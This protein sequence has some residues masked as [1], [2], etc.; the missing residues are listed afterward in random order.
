VVAGV[1][2]LLLIWLGIWVVIRDERG[3]EVGRVRLPSGGSVTQELETSS[4]RPGTPGRGVGGEGGWD[5][6]P[7][8]PSPAIAPFDA[9]GAKSHQQAWAPYLGVPVEIENSLG[10]KFMLIPPGEFD[11]GS[12]EA[13]VAELRSEGTAVKQKA[14]YILRVAAQAPRHRVR[15]TRPFWL[16]RHE[17]T[18][19]QFRR[20]V[21]DSGYQTEGE[22]DGKGGYG[23]VDGQQTQDPRFSWDAD[24]GFDQTDDH[25]LVNV[26]WS[27]AAA[28]CAW[29]SKKEGAESYLPSEA[30]WEYA[31]R[32]G[33]ATLWYSGDEANVA[34]DGHAWFDV[35]AGQKT[36][37]VGQK[38]PNAWGLFDMHGNVWEWCRDWFDPGY[39]SKS[40][41]NDP[42]GPSE[43]SG[44]VYRGGGWAS[45][46]C[47][48][49]TSYRF[50][51][52][53]FARNCTRGFRLARQVAWPEAGQT[54]TDPGQP[55]ATPAQTPP[56]P[57]ASSADPGTPGSGAGGEGETSPLPGTP[58][59]GVGGEGGWNLPPNAPPPAIAPFDAAGAKSH[60]Q[61]WAKYLGVGVEMENS[62]AMPL[63]LIPPGEFDMGSADADVAF[64]LK[65]AKA[66]KEPDPDHINRLSAEV[67]RH[68]VRIT[69]PFWLGRHEV[70]RGQFRR[71]VEDRAYRT[72]AERDGKGGFGLLDGQHK[73]DPRFVWNADLGFEQTDEH[74]VV[75]VSWSDASAFCAWLSEKEGD[76]SYLPSEAQ[77]EYACRAGTTTP[78]YSGGLWS[79]L[80]SHAWFVDT[81]RT[82]TRP[83]GQKSA[84]PWG[85]FD[86]HGNVWE[87]CADW[88]DAAYYA[89]SPR[90]D[91][92]GASA[93]PYR[94]S[95]G[96][97]WTNAAG[98]C[99]SAYRCGWQVPLGRADCRGFRLARQFDDGA[100]ESRA[101]E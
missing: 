60:Q 28:F 37:P 59:R 33:T 2:G 44:R 42:T 41:L 48:C 100:K 15:I 1:G 18:R 35:N 76:K 71:F 22:Q 49:R 81:A 11:M 24:L 87:W 53:S 4:P 29:L 23:L 17:V 50:C 19:G 10:M 58:G 13:E 46:A 94:V 93:G 38:S 96:G 97:S 32:A 75:N 86:V 8:A 82:G 65:R 7:N 80:K 30:Q 88:Y 40:P 98:G 20:F 45:E 62:L 5:L 84:N 56:S 79:E 26:S 14:G 55:S 36:H 3:Q 9:A 78:W 91:P 64:N 43:G 12:T 95:R 73:Q 27:D 90:D 47:E 39:Y 83:V 92:P 72:E 61:A 99:T 70:T 69:Q 25:P 74:P 89:T 6:P 85:L 57:E 21:E 16:G 63:V 31:C 101:K 66:A 67:P 51:L 68:R 34:L 52:P 54:T 77:W